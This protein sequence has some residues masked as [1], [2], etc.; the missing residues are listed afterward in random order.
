MAVPADLPLRVAVAQI[1]ASPEQLGHATRETHSSLS[2]GRL[3]LVGSPQQ[4]VEGTADG[5]HS[6]TG[7]L[8][9]SRCGL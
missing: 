5:E 9:T 6:Q 1:Q 3:H 8:A 4:L 2:R 7:R